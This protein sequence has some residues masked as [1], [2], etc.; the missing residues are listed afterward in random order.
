MATRT[1][2][3]GRSA[4]PGRRKRA[5]PSAPRR[6]A[7]KSAPEE[8]T[9]SLP[10]RMIKGLW[11][12]MA[13]VVGGI[14]RSIGSSAKGLDPAH[15]RDGLAFL[16]LGLAVL[17]AVR[18]WFGLSGAAGGVIHAAAAGSVGVVGGVG[19]GGWG[20]VAMRLRRAPGPP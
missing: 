17:V 9:P 18:E 6:T 4:S 14:A 10:V 15:R 13:H 2:S 19:A 20:F 11:M 5:A 8:A 3:P 16:L 1:T 7:T 12:G